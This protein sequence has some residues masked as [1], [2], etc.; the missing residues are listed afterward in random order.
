[1]KDKIINVL[2]ILLVCVS[3]I[4][5][6]YYVNYKIKAKKERMTNQVDE[7]KLDES[8]K[9]TLIDKIGK[10]TLL[11]DA[12]AIYTEGHQVL[13]VERKNNQIYAYVLAIIETYS[14]RGSEYVSTSGMAGPFTLI[15]DKQ[16]Q[17]LE[18][19][20]PEDREHYEESLKSIFPEHL[21]DQVFSINYKSEYFQKQID[22]YIQKTE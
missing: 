5:T 16:Y 11:M 13:G 10:T 9:H 6:G 22:A 15:F 8:I 7:L 21:I 3:T 14:L 2:L 17:F 20:V 19:Q 12:N 4:G 18:Y 1:M